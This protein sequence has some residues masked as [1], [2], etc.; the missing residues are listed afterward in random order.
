MAATKA[1]QQAAM[2]SRQQGT[3]PVSSAHAPAHSPLAKSFHLVCF[4]LCIAQVVYLAASFALGQWLVDAAGHGIP[5]DFVNV[6]AAG[7]LTL[8]GHP[9]AA[10]EWMTHKGIE[11]A[12]VGYDFEGYYGWYY[13]PPFLAVAAL[14]ALFPYAIAYA[15]WVA[16]TL[17]IYIVTIRWIVGHRLGYLFAGAFPAVLANA[18][19]GQNGF[20]TASLMGGA[21]G[22]MEKRPVLAGC[23]LGFLTYKPHFGILFPLVLLAAKRWT[24]FWTAAAVTLAMA[25]L[26]WLAFGTSTWQGFL[27][28]LPVA[29][30]KYLSD[31]EAD[32]GKLQ[33]IF[34]LVRT[35]GGGEHL[36][37]SMQILFIVAVAIFLG[38]LWRGK[39]PFAL[40]AAALG[41]GALLATPYVY[42]YDLVVLAVPVAFLI[43]LAL[44]DGFLRGEAMALALAAALIFIF[45][46][47]KW[48][49]GLLGVL[50]VAAL[51]VRRALQRPE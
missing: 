51:I 10:Y 29:S 36:A 43:R 50:I 3:I 49:V 16:T 9:A 47:V 24:V 35:L 37:W 18:M 33:S 26:S 41:T 6:W 7:K 34:G 21:L 13:P 30:H 25:A 42:L 1:F 45:P 28:L 11:N 17:P 39:K 46:L 14:L 27:Q 44:K 40:K 15:G 19:V 2:M 20:I 48:P 5:T 8:S 23:C 38:V 31:G 32:W 12:A 4:G 22:F